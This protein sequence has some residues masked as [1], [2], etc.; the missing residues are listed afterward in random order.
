MP[1]S[2]PLMNTCAVPRV[3]LPKASSHSVEDYR[4]GMPALRAARGGSLCVVDWSP[5]R[6]FG[7]VLHAL[8]DPDTR[9]ISVRIRHACLNSTLRK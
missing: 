8:R 5:P 6:D 9:V 2:E 3:G 1:S 4:C 7:Q